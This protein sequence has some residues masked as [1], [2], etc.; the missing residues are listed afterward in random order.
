MK[1]LP[2]YD[3][4]AFISY[5]HKDKVWVRDV[6]LPILVK[7]E[8]K[9][10]IDYRDF[11]PGAPS[12]TEMER[13]VKNSWKTIL[14]LTPN[15]IN[16]AW[17][18][19]ESIMIATLD[20]A[21]RE[22]R[23]LPILVEQCDIPLRINYLTFLDFSNLANSKL[24]W[25]RLIAAF[26]KET[27]DTSSGTEK[28]RLPNEVMPMSISRDIHNELRKVLIDTDELATQTRLRAMFADPR[29]SSFKSGLPEASS[30]AERADLLIDF[31]ISRKLRNGESL[32]GVFLDVLRSKIDPNDS[33]IVSVEKVIELMKNSSVNIMSGD[34]KLSANEIPFSKTGSLEPV[35]TELIR[36]ILEEIRL[37]RVEQNNLRRIIDATA[38]SMKYVMNHGVKV[39][40]PEVAKSLASIQQSVDNG[41]S[42]EQQLELTLPL[43]PFLL[44]Y[45]VNLGKGVDL[46]EMWEELLARFTKNNHD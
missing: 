23:I 16:S 7:N 46:R 43:I 8:I 14:I 22:R 4:D 24:Q 45:K 30:V 37:G 9:V 18:E 26:D 27:T 36:K 44:E 41:L 19:F 31:L 20:P 42:L 6:L 13:A 35:D 34:P 33:R 17:S 29:L 15:Y 32:A 1:I 3:Y 21:G 25:A 11:E 40:D 38:R 28:T 39:N 10:I 5:S 12:I 2:T